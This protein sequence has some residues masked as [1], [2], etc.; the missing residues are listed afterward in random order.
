MNEAKTPPLILHVIHHL[1]IGGME[2]GVVNLINGLSP[3]DFRHAILCIEDFS[4]FSKR[5]ERD[6]VP[7]IALK[8]SERGIWG[9]RREIYKICKRLKPA[10]VHSRNLSGLDALL[11]A[12]LAGVRC[13]VH[14]EHGWDV[15]DLTGTRLRPQLLRRLHAPLI[16]NYVAV[17]RDLERY[18][19]DRVGIR[20]ARVNQIYN[21]VDTQRF[22]PDFEARPGRSPTDGLFVIGTVGRLQLVKDQQTLLRGFARMIEDEPGMREFAR[23]VIVGDGPLAMQLREL[24]ESLG[25]AAITSF[26]GARDD[27]EKQL[28]SFDLFVL[29]SLNEGISNTILEAMATGLPVVASDV[30]GNPELLGTCG[31]LVKPGDVSQLSQ[32]LSDYAKNPAAA[33]AVGD[34]VR[35]RAERLFSLDTM[36]ARYNELY[37]RILR[38]DNDH[39]SAT[40]IGSTCVMSERK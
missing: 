36:V 3:L 33:R 30:G 17:S 26:V 25:I 11:P 20:S 35:T 21:G 24:A 34:T 40:T 14:S 28:R 13:L 32:A 9:T 31:T 7:V 19:V 37:Q 27:I 4:D 8:R 18:L 22:R 2:N 1:V 12:R 15:S 5:L 39:A 10:I 38:S 16:S 29:C 6:D 23:L